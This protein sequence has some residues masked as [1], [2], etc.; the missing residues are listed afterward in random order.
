MK[1]STGRSQA[2]GSRVTA[3]RA[4]F[5]LSARSDVLHEFDGGSGQIALHGLDHVGGVLGTAYPTAADV[6]PT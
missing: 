3:V 6:S 5:A 2:A 4:P 1:F